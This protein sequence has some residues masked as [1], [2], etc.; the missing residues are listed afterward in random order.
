[1]TKPPAL[2]RL[3]QRAAALILK[4]KQQYDDLVSRI[5]VGVY[6]LRSTPQGAFSL[7]FVSP[8]MAAMLGLK[9]ESLRDDAS[10]VYQA[11]HPEDRDGFVRLNED[12]I[13][14]QQPFDWEGR[15]L[16]DG[17]VKW[18]QIASTPR[19]LEDGDVVWD[20]VVLDITAR[21]QAALSLRT[22]LRDKEALLRE[23]HHR[24]KNNLQVINSLLRLETSRSQVA[25]TKRVLK[26]M[27]GRIMSMALLHETLYRSERFGQVDLGRYLEQLAQQLFRAGSSSGLLRLE[28]DLSP[29]QVGIDQA[30]PCGL[31]VNELLTNSLKHAFAEGL[32]GAV[33]IGLRQDADGRVELRVMDTGVG[34][35]GDFEARR[36]AS[37]GLQLV[38]DLARQL[39]GR[40]EIGPGP[41]AGFTVAFIAARPHDTG[42]VFGPAAGP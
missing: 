37:L 13:K 11:I 36:G 9:A 35:P 39:G 6:I 38:D 5:P 29:V 14:S 24:V 25:D 2:R 21:T 27:Q 31:I 1:M 28:L 10:L 40:L 30:I 4:S 34:L 18:L 16:V 41:G 26:D 17:T 20:G 22:S 7:D 8:R 12:G 32:G 23:V 19:S 42:P 33:R 3:R 15:V